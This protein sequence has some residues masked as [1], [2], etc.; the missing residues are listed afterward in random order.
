[1]I[2]DIL[3]CSELSK[4]FLGAFF[5]AFFAFIL[6]LI[7]KRLDLNHTVKRNN[8]LA[9]IKIQQACARFDHAIS[10]NIKEL[11]NLE[12]VLQETI[13]DDLLLKFYIVQPKYVHIDFEEL[14]NLTKVA[15]IQDSLNLFLSI[16]DINTIMTS[17]KEANEITRLK[18][19]NPAIP[20]DLKKSI[21]AAELSRIEDQI[22]QLITISKKVYQLISYTYILAPKYKS[23]Q[24]SFTSKILARFNITID[25]DTYTEQEIALFE[26]EYKKLLEGLEKPKADF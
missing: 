7:L 23:G 2:M 3:F 1:M 8:F 25:S 17:L 9:V 10:W 19:E 24:M 21:L 26:S 5:G 13:N 16:D 15:F 6:H 18:L 4:A 11:K 14:V 20:K 12:K 22:E